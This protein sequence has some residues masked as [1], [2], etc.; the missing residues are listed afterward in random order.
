[1]IS[2]PVAIRAYEMF[3]D[4][5]ESLANMFELA[6]QAA[7]VFGVGDPEELRCRRC[8]RRMVPRATKVSR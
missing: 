6:M 2:V 3:G 8:F 1:M 7:V 4:H 5:H